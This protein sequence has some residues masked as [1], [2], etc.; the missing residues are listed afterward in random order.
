MFP[1]SSPVKDHQTVRA[2]TLT[3]VQYWG[4]DFIVVHKNQ[5]FHIASN[6]TSQ[7]PI[8]LRTYV[9]CGRLVTG[10]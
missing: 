8:T 2:K 3:Y 10:A 4:R 5:F 1:V 9:L 7:V 6:A